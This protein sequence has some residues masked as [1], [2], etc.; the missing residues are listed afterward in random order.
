MKSMPHS[1]RIAFK[2]FKTLQSILSIL[3]SLISE[4]PQNYIHTE[5]TN[6]MNVFLSKAILPSEARCSNR[7]DSRLMALT[8][9]A[10]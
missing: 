8:L 7:G 9:P 10:S 1:F 4:I 5:Y 2:D 6:W 3:D